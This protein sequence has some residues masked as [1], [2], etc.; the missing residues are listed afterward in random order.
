MC[1]RSVFMVL[2]LCLFDS[3]TI[4]DNAGEGVYV[5]T[6][7]LAVCLEDG[8]DCLIDVNILNQVKLS[9]QICQWGTGFLNPGKMGL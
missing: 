7:D 4:W 8:G 3:Y 2:Y 5:V 1:I 6:V 9:K